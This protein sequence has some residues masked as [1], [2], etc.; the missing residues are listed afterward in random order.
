MKKKIVVSA[1]AVGLIAMMG[2]GSLAYFNASGE[3]VNTITTGDVDI[4]VNEYQDEDGT[5]WQDQDNVTPGAEITKIAEVENTGS[6][7]VYVRVS[8]EEAFSKVGLDPDLADVDF[9]TKDWTYSDGYYY[10]NSVLGAGETTEPLFTTVTFSTEM[11]NDYADVEYKL[12]VKAQAVQS[13]NNGDSAQT[14]EG[15]PEVMGD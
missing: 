3:A 2:F 8:V 12:T 6:N 11:D 4:T 1:V 7:D 5:P 15:W 10:Y 9:N 14:A 13:D